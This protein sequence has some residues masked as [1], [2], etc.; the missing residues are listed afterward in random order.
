MSELPTVAPSELTGYL[1][2]RGWRRADTWRGAIVWSLDASCHLLVPDRREYDD[3]DE[4][5][6][7]AVHKLAAYEARP[8]QEVL[9]D[10]AEPMVDTQ[11][12][13]TFPETPSGTIPLTSGLKVVQGIHDLMKTTARTVLEGPHLLFEGRR[14]QTV[15]NFLHQVR[16]GAARPGSYILTARVPLSNTKKTQGELFEA[17]I[18]G[19]D[20]SRCLRTALEAAHTAAITAVNE[21]QRTDFF[22]EQ[23]EHGVSANL[24]KALADLGGSSK[25]RPF[26]V[27]FSWGREQVEGE[28]NEPISF[29]GPMTSALARAGR[30][31]EDLAKSGDAQ[32]IGRV[33]SLSQRQG[34]GPKIKI[35]GELRTTANVVR[36]ALWIV[37]T[38]DQY[39]AAFEAQRL[40]QDLEVR[41]R[42]VTTQRRL[43]MRPESFHV[44][45]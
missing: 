28:R 34:E 13:R 44:R 24:C 25:N 35:V 8:E 32:I 33:E 12:Y 10:I 42:L 40:R 29:T 20:V 11:Y 3:D 41:G 43:E 4:L 22:D 17:N 23:V 27:G 5:L 36:R 21:G 45:E 37:V 30:E 39:D 15:D 18:S 26:E 19:R 38:S 16:L 1:A 31:L 7:E 9:L 2:S 6:A 14:G